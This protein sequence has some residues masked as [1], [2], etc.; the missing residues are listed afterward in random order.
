[1][2]TLQ[3]TQ[4]SPLPN[5]AWLHHH[6][7]PPLLAPP[8]SPRVTKVPSGSTT[9]KHCPS[10]I[11]ATRGVFETFNNPRPLPWEGLSSGGTPD[12]WLE[13]PSPPALGGWQSWSL[14]PHAPAPILPLCLSTCSPLPPTSPTLILPLSPSEAPWHHRGPAEVI[15]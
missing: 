4:P 9:F 10:I 6:L 5:P 12:P 7:P 8:A 1:M 2:Q 14:C 15:R 13:L 11:Q 3:S